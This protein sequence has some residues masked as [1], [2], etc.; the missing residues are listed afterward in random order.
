M[1]GPSI[2]SSLLK[3]CTIKADSGIGHLVEERMGVQE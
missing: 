2:G 1:L 3:R